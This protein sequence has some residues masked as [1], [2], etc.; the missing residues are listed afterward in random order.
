MS[1]EG[2]EAVQPK[3][4]NEDMELPRVN[5]AASNARACEHTLALSSSPCFFSLTVCVRFVVIA[6]RIKSAGV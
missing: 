3:T 6:G 1:P 4:K 2:P 5:A